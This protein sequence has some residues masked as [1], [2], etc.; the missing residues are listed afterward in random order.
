MEFSSIQNINNPDKKTINIV[1]KIDIE[2]G[3][4]ITT[5]IEN[6]IA[7]GEASFNLRKSFPFLLVHKKTRHPD[8]ISQKRVGIEK[9]AA[10]W[11]EEYIDIKTA[12]EEIDKNKI[13]I[14]RFLWLFFFCWP[15]P[16]NQ[17]KNG[18]TK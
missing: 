5:K 1:E 7:S 10:G 15:N 16:V 18:K 13:V 8:A 4:N 11:L 6:K 17:I 12:K 14:K 3:R 9:Y 2:R